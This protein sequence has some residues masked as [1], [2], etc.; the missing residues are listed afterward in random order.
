[1]TRFLK[2][3][4][5]YWRY[6]IYSA[7]AQLKNE[8]AGSFLNWLWWIL[9]PLLFMLV[10][11]FVYTIVFGNKQDYLCAFIFIGY[12]SWSFFQR[13]VNASVRIIKR[14]QPVLSKVYLPKFILILSTMLV[15]GFKMLIGFGLVFITMVVYR[16]PPTVHMLWLVP[17]LLLLFLITF[18]FGC[19]LLHC[20]VYLEDLANIVNVV[21][22]LLFYLSGIF[23]NPEVQLASHPLQQYFLIRL[24]P[25]CYIITQLR[26]T[27]LY[28][29]A[30]MLQWYLFW[31]IVGAV[32]SVIGISLIY[33]Y[34]RRYVKSV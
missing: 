1:M 31:V 9:D 17:Y 23:Y 11:T 4:H 8:V 33:K 3:I 16:V 26:N 15:N 32:V 21:L 22:R 7:R 6:M 20:G 10:Y 19:I 34:E 27:M 29:R 28:N 12:T 14:Y 13:S 24:N 25:T 5:K 30:P 2:D 18:G